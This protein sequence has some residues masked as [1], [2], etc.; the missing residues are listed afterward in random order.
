MEIAKTIVPK[1]SPIL[2]A[3]TSEWCT[4][5]NTLNIKKTPQSIKITVLSE[6]GVKK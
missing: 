1:G 2:C 3:M 4:A 6:S 5:E